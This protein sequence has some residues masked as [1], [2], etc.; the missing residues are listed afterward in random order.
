MKHMDSARVEQDRSFR[1]REETR[2][3]EW[4]EPVPLE[5]ALQDALRS[6]KECTAACLAIVPALPPSLRGPVVTVFGAA[7]VAGG[8]IEEEAR[9]RPAS[10][11]LCIRIID[12]NLRRLDEAGRLTEGAAAAARRCVNRCRHALAA[13][14][15]CKEEGESV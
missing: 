5:I 14:Y 7:S 1:L 10:L 6:T 4:T 15:L 13:L 3:F 9:D 11:E 8:R 2:A 12:G